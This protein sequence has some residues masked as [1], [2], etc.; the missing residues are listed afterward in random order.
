MLLATEGPCPMCGFY[1]AR[2]YDSRAERAATS[3]RKRESTDF[4]CAARCARH[5]KSKSALA[6]GPQWPAAGSHAS[7]RGRPTS[8]QSPGHWRSGPFMVCGC[9]FTSHRNVRPGVASTVRC[10]MRAGRAVRCRS[11]GDALE[12][13]L[14]RAEVLDEGLIVHRSALDVA[15]RE[16]EGDELAHHWELL[17]RGG[18]VV[19][20][21]RLGPNHVVE[22]L[23]CRGGLELSIR[24]SDHGHIKLG[25][26]RHKCRV[27]RIHAHAHARA[28]VRDVERHE[29]RGQL[30]EAGVRRAAQDR[31][32][33]V[34]RRA[35]QAPDRGPVRSARVF[36]VAAVDPARVRKVLHHEYA[37]AADLRRQHRVE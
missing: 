32:L 7:L 13:L 15:H 28:S 14:T 4:P 34:H 27:G 31:V 37:E 5:P 12:P 25:Q 29:G 10:A 16:I 22:R 24:L 30:V 36:A 26:R 1:I 11:F 35:L 2:A 20:S 18:V 8:H 9:S 21:E 19:I 3:P 6:C 23:A 17:E 33:A